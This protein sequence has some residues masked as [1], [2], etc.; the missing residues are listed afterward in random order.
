LLKVFKMFLC[1]SNLI[2]IPTCFGQH[3]TIIRG[4][5]FLGSATLNIVDNVQISPSVCG[6]VSH[7]LSS[8]SCLLL[9]VLCLFFIF[10]VFSV[11]YDNSA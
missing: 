6:C 8:S 5:L 3:M 7:C 10:S 9:L 1:M 11:L 4:L 2:Y